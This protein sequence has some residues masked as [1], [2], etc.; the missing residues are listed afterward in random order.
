MR[1]K[2]EPIIRKSKEAKFVSG[3]LEIGKPLKTWLSPRG[4]M[5]V[6]GD[7]AH[8]TVP[9]SGQGGS[10]AIEDAAVLAIALE[11]GG[12]KDIALSLA[13]VEKIRYAYLTHAYFVKTR[14]Q[15]NKSTNNSI[16]DQT[17]TLRNHPTGRRGCASLCYATARFRK[18]TKRPI[19]AT[20]TPSCLDL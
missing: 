6:I 15:F 5:I 14:N 1:D 10:Q 13:A 20:A 16:M 11:L 4:R 12:K 17:P 3:N 9:S 18:P 8:A 7:A 19:G 2:L